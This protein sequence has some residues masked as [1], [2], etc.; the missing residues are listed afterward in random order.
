MAKV[1]NMSGIEGWDSESFAENAAVARETAEMTAKYIADAKSKANW[2]SHKPG[3]ELI[4]YIS[5]ID[6]E[7]KTL[8]HRLLSSPDDR[9]IWEKYL[10]LHLYEVLESAPAMISRAI[11]EMESPGS[12]SKADPRKYKEAAREFRK[13]LNP[14]RKDTDFI[15]A[16]T[17]IRNSVAAHHR[18]RS[19]SSMDA[20][21]A[22][23]LANVSHRTHRGTPLQGQVLDYSLRVGFAV[24]TFANSVSEA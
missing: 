24:Q 10:A 3:L 16:L 21:I 12:A 4:F 11:Q 9:Y 18:D 6:Y 20:S 5:L 22:W 1:N 14:I 23:M 7:T 17:T 15:S 19:A 13:A 8:I 2:G